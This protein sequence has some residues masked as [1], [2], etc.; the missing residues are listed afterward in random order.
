MEGTAHLSLKA[1]CSVL[2]LA[3]LAMIITPGGIGSF[4]IFVMQTLVMYSISAPLGNA[5]GWLM[6]GVSTG[7]VITAGFTALLLL[8]YLNRK[9]NESSQIAPIKDIFTD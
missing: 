3:T 7:I 4:P 6:W 5:F 8:P 9:K 1:A 2:A